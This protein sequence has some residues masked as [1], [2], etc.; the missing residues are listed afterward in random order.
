LKSVLTTSGASPVFSAELQSP[1]GLRR[2]IT[3]G[4]FL[5]RCSLFN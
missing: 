2:L 4:F 3:N 1:C 5:D